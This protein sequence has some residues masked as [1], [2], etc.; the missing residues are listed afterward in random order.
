MTQDCLHNS[1]SVDTLCSQ[2]ERERCLALPNERQLELSLTIL[3]LLGG[4]TIV[5]ASV[6]RV[7]LKINFQ[8]FLFLGIAQVASEG[9][10]DTRMDLTQLEESGTGRSVPTTPLQVSPQGMQCSL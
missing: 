10:D 8:H 6:L 3:A 1:F 9:M 5:V 4:A 2:I 7:N